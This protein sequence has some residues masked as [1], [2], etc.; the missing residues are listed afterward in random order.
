MADEALTGAVP[1]E[2]GHSSG[3]PGGLRFQQ[4]LMVFGELC[5]LINQVGVPVL[6]DNLFGLS[7]G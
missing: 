5:T 6:F 7:R 4:L 1:S 2:R 3:E